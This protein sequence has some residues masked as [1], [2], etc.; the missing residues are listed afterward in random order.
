MRRGWLTIMQPSMV[1]GCERFYY[2]ESGDGCYNLAAE[3][4]IPLSKFKYVSI[5][6]HTNWHAFYR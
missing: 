5:S 1:S 4:G 3:A 2:V 6:V